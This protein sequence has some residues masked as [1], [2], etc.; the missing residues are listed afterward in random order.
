MVFVTSAV[1]S[2]HLDPGFQGSLCDQ[3]T[4]HL[5]RIAIATKFYVLAH[6]FIPRRDGDQRAAD[7][8]IDQLA[9]QVAVASKDTHS[10]P[11]G[12][13][14][15]PIANGVLPSLTTL[16]NFFFFVHVLT[17]YLLVPRPL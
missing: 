13:A 15:Q 10:R 9:A 5:G 4:D 11:L 17:W 1:K 8:I 14:P 6:I 2:H 7:R 16:C 12:I 3:L